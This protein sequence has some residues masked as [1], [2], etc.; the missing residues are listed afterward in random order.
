M[1]GKVCKQALL[2]PYDHGQPLAYNLGRSR[3]RER[4]RLTGFGFLFSLFFSQLIPSDNLK[5]YFPRLGALLL[6]IKKPH[7]PNAKAG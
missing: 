2:L 3:G 4:R 7:R 6:T 5:V 1:C